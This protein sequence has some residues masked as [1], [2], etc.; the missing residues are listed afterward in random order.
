MPEIAAP[1]AIAE[2]SK[3][4]ATATSAREPKRKAGRGD[5]DDDARNDEENRVLQ[6]SARVQRAHSD[7]MHRRGFQRPS[8]SRPWQAGRRSADRR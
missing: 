8:R 4:R 1:S 3:A 2:N 7:V 6:V 5:R